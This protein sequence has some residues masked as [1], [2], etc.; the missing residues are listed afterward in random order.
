MHTREGMAPV[1][2]AALPEAVRIKVEEAAE[3]TA[4]LLGLSPDDARELVVEHLL[5]RTV[6][7]T[8][9]TGH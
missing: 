2:Y 3:R 7:D 8:H 4:A 1:D 5:S 6:D 9:G